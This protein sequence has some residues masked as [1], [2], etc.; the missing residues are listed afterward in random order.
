M[1]E[2]VAPDL[3]TCKFHQNLQLLQC[4]VE[5]KKRRES[6]NLFVQ[7]RQLYKSGTYF[8]FVFPLVD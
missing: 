6:K 5:A 2:S 3:S 4:A 8:D 7:K 1:D